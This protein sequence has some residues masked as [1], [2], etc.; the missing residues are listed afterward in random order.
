MKKLQI[1]I[2]STYTDLKEERQAAVGAILN[3][4]HIPAGMELFTAGDES[5]L[6]TVKRWIEE[7]DIY[8]LILGGR[9]GAIEPKSLKSYTH[10]EYEYAI[11]KGKP[12]FAVVMKEEAL[13]AKVRE[14]GTGVIELD[15]RVK[16]EEFKKSVLTKMCSFFV[17]EKDIKLAVLETLG[18]FQ[19]RYEFTGWISGKEVEVAKYLVEEN[20]NLLKENKELRSSLEKALKST[21]KEDS[22]EFKTVRKALIDIKIE[23]PDALAGGKKGVTNS[24]YSI[25]VSN[26]DAF[27][28]GVISGTDKS[29]GEQFLFYK[30]A[31]VLLTFGLVEKGKVPSGAYFQRIHTSRLGYEFL[32]YCTL[33]SLKEKKM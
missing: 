8:L 21:N 1:F 10:V 22:S 3:A 5:Q 23:I 9:Y 16:Y 4:G 31:P 33:N 12:F 24:A 26:S 15:N 17:D 6:D 11:E 32:K 30:V 20:R 27:A 18:D 13:Q 28:I 2:S 7:S 14:H 19:R 29:P 25:F